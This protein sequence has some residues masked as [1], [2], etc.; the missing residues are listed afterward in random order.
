MRQREFICFLQI[1]IIAG[2]LHPQEVQIGDGVLKFEGKVASGVFW[3][4][5]DVPMKDESGQPINQNGSFTG[6]DG[7]VDIIG[8]DGKVYMWNETDTRT[9]L[10]ADLT[11]TYTNGPAGLRIRLRADDALADKNRAVIARYAY[12]WVNVFNDALKFTGGFIDLSNNVWGTLGDGD[13]DIGG[14]GVRIEFKPFALFDGLDLGELNIGAFLMIPSAPNPNKIH[15]ADSISVELY[16]AGSV[17]PENVLKETALG[18]R[19]THPWFYIGAQVKLDGLV[20]GREILDATKKKMWSSADDELRFMFGAGVTVLP[21][22]VLTAEGNFEGLGNWSARGTGDMRQTLQ[23]SLSRLS[24]PYLN[25]VF[26]GLKAQELLWGYDLLELCGWD[27][28]LKP[29]M[30][31]KPF[32]G[33]KANDTFSA[34]LEFGFGGGYLSG[35]HPVDGQQFVNETSNFYVKPNVSCVFANGFSLKAWYRFAAVEYGNLANGTAY[36]DRKR[37]NLPRK[38]D[39]L[40]LVDSIV[41]HQIAVEFEW[42]F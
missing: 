27:F 12:G 5:D 39:N 25:K 26:L 9:S 15:D 24:V 34:A 7:K 36:A 40:T 1:L 2:A 4:A 41:R 42:V 35:T 21:E 19:W 16:G 30:Q 22:L 20:D 11:A 17:S 6:S 33:Y 14:N 28:E 13:W 23:Y 31:L 29:W 32:I 8:P 3:D 38:T 10:R 18:F 37:S